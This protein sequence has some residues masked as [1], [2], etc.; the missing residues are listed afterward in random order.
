MEV[1]AT[2]IHPF[3]V[4]LTHQST[5]KQAILELRRVI[6][7][8]LCTRKHLNNIFG[9]LFIFFG[10]VS[11]ILWHLFTNSCFSEHVRLEKPFSHV[12]TKIQI[13]TL[14]EYNNCFGKV[15]LILFSQKSRCFTPQWAQDTRKSCKREE[16]L[17]LRHG[18]VTFRIRNLNQDHVSWRSVE[19]VCQVS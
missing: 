19:S 14:I 13:L 9:V 18:S 17:G 7:V 6:V 5:K 8:I 1:Y 12:W 11:M 4:E 15:L 2:N 3:T 16:S 10:H